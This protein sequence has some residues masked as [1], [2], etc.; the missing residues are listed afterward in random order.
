MWPKEK[1]M[2]LVLVVLALIAMPAFAQDPWLC[3]GDYIAFVTDDGDTVTGAES[4]LGTDW[5][6]LINEEGLKHFGTDAVRLDACNWY[7]GRPAFC[8]STEGFAGVFMMTGQRVFTYI[9]MSFDIGS[10]QGNKTYVLKGK[11][12]K[13]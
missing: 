5:K 11:C 8:E 13:L 6:L 12:S 2:R 3:I 10:G 7:E 4:G 1:F 9:A